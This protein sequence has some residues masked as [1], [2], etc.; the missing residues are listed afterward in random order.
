MSK[1]KKTTTNNK[2]KSERKNEQK[3]EQLKELED[4][5]YTYPEKDLIAYFKEI[6]IFGK[7]KEHYQRNLSLLHSLDIDSIDFAIARFYHMDNSLDPVRRNLMAVIPL[8]VAYLTIAFNVNVIKWIGFG[9]VTISVLA[10]LR[11][12][13]KDRKNRIV[14][15]YML[16]TFEQVKARK[17][18]DEK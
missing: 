4:V 1:K 7:K 11:Q 5:I 8:F 6:F 18:K 9:F 12:L 16:K 13:D 14:T 3:N 2:Q 15:G 17:E 10:V